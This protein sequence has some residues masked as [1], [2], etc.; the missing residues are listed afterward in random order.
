MANVSGAVQ[1]ETGIKHGLSIP[2]QSVAGEQSIDVGTLLTESIKL[3]GSRFLR[4]PILR[5]RHPYNSRNDQQR[6][7]YLY[8]LCS[9]VC[10]S[11]QVDSFTDRQRKTTPANALALRRSGIPRLT[12]RGWLRPADGAA[13]P[14]TRSFGCPR[15]LA[16]APSDIVDSA[17][18][19]RSELSAILL[20]A[21]P[22][23]RT[24]IC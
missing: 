19:P 18:P 10:N 4:N 22:S 3:T 21:T 16:D 2:F 5:E 17:P 8:A 20:A 9:P 23:R 6:V 24:M 1:I 15:E 13:G 14:M 11:A 7:N 12:A